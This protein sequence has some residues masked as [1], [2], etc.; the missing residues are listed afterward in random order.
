MDEKFVLKHRVSGKYLVIS[1]FAKDA[2][3]HYGT[4]NLL[5][6]ATKLDVAEKEDLEQQTLS[7]IFPEDEWEREIVCYS[8]L[9]TKGM[10]CY[11]SR[12]AGLEY[13]AC[14]KDKNCDEERK[15]K[16]IHMCEMVMLST[17]VWIDNQSH[18]GYGESD[19][20]P[21]IPTS[22][23]MNELETCETFGTKIKET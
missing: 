15:T 8:F 9:K 21:L 12:K 18:N 4:T 23:N 13:P 3:I 2:V 6:L 7:K 17:G 10:T 1:K 14:C 19:A 20:Q 22:Q 5:D 16:P 11:E